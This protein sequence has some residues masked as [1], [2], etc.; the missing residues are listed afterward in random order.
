MVPNPYGLYDDGARSRTLWAIREGLIV[1]GIL[2]FWVVIAVVL[3]VVVFLISLPFALARIGPPGFAVVS[4]VWTFVGPLAFL[5][6]S[7][8]VLVRAGTVLV[9]HYR[10]GDGLTFEPAPGVS[11]TG[12]R[13]E[14]SDEQGETSDEVDRT[15]EPAGESDD[16]ADDTGG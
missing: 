3:T 10:T 16:S 11:G 8:Y 12:E 13:E 5:N 15:D 14:T 7:L 2:L 1:G 6:A 4:I 9:D